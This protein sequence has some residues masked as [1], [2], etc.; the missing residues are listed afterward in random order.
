[1]KIIT[2]NVL[3]QMRRMSTH[4][5]PFGVKDGLSDHQQKLMARGLPQRRPIDGVKSVVVV[6]SGKGGVGKST[7]AVN[8]ALAMAA[9]EP[10]RNIGLL[11]ADVYGPSLP[12]MM[13]LQGEPFLDDKNRMIPLTN[14]G[15]KCMS[16]GFLVDEKSAIVWRGPMVMSAVQRLLRQ[17]AWAPLDYLFVDMPPGT[18]DIQL[19]LSQNI[20]INGAVI[21]STPQDIALL[22][23]RRGAE[24]FRKVDVPVLGLVEN[25]SVYIC[26]QCG[27]QEHIFGQDGAKGLAEDMGVDIL[28]SVPLTRAIRE[29]SDSGQPIVVSDPGS[30]QA[31]VYRDIARTIADKLSTLEKT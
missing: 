24:M 29:T 26:P 4:D 30:P 2:R 5:N 31:T 22:D 10:K 11:D 9:N 17:V 25:M 20:P 8:L 12:T 3:H 19:S 28:G 13:N 23:A 14:F 18:G 6:A 21:V 27:H 7:T 15:I 16:M 1:M